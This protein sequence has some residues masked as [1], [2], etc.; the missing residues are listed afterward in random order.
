[1]SF[2]ELHSNGNSTITVDTMVMETKF[3]DG[4]EKQSSIAGVV[5][6][7]QWKDIKLISHSYDHM[8]FIFCQC[9]RT[10]VIIS[11]SV[12]DLCVSFYKRF[13]CVGV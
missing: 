1:M 5:L 6:Y 4:N 3:W 9:D 2:R 12:V 11:F 13:V 7:W 8:H 10:Q